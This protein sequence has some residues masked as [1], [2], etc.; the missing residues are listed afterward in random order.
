[1]GWALTRRRPRPTRT[2]D[3]F[4]IDVGLPRHK[5]RHVV[6]AAHPDITRLARSIVTPWTFIK[7][8]A[9]P[10]EVA[11]ALPAGWTI[12]APVFMMT[13]DLTARA[14]P[15]I[16]PSGY[17]ARL[18]KREP[19]VLSVEMRDTEGNPGANGSAALWEGFCIFDQIVTAPDHRRRGLGT[20]VMASLAMAARQLG[21]TRGVLVATD[22]G[23]A[24]YTALGWTLASPVT[25]AV[26]ADDS[27]P[28]D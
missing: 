28:V 10:A 3:G 15:V 12:E 16:A 14:K 21:A 13:C 25:S 7:A 5:G 6:T 27:A 22:D 8:C 9:Q 24:L 2:P 23:Y 18:V 20:C 4:Y 17:E 19:S 26:I 1:M 11:A